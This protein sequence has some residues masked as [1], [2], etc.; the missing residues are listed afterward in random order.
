MTHGLE[1]L[2][3]L[4]ASHHEAPL[5]AR[6]RFALA[7]AEAESFEREAAALEGMREC[8]VVN[9]CNRLEAYGLADDLS[10]EPALRAL[11]HR[12][13][14][15]ERDFIQNHFVL[16]TNLAALQHA[17]EVC[18]GL[19]SQMVGETEILGQMKA[20]YARAKANDATGKTLNR[21]F[22]RGF[23]AAKTARSR[24][25]IGQGQ[26]SVG[27]IAADLA[28]RIFGRLEASRVLLLGS[29]EVGEK[30][31]RALQ[32][33]GATDVTVSS[34]TFEKAK[35]VAH[36]FGGAAIDF[37]DFRSQLPRFD[38]VVASTSAPE[39]IVSRASVERCLA[40]RPERAMFLIDLALPR[41]ID[42]EAESM[43]N[44][45]LYNLDDLSAI[46]NENLQSR[47][48]EIEQARELIQRS[49]WQLWLNL[50]RRKLM[51]EARGS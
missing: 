37:E 41:D 19:Q 39:A 51:A 11:F 6:E 35:A 24:T 38:I 1:A 43:D 34:R 42:P 14:G 36:R 27:N 29:G 46:A 25:A 4:G 50:R 45:Y 49:A 32:N 8:V 48:A 12:R 13:L 21:V 17:L 7:P 3:V 2:F 44:I 5:E 18:S 23:Q 33:R 15:V 30:T 9:T 20:A 40:E 47:R 22:E 26:I 28:E 10:V 31:A 16:R